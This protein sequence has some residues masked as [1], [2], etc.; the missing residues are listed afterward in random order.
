MTTRK[1]QKPAK[2]G[3]IPASEIK[4]AVK[5]VAKK[6]TTEANKATVK[7]PTVKSLQVELEILSVQLS[8]ANDLVSALEKQAVLNLER[9]SE[10]YTENMIERNKSWVAITK[11]RVVRQ[12]YRVTSYLQGL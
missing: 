3:S 2:Q 6:T 8:Y 5:A 10:L 1:V 12:L 11:E 9:Y 4:A 7:K